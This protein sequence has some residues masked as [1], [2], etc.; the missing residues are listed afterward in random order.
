[1][2]VMSTATLLRVLTGLLERPVACGVCFGSL[3]DGESCLWIA[4]APLGKQGAPHPTFHALLAFK[5]D[6]GDQPVQLGIA[7]VVREIVD[8]AELRNGRTLGAQK[9]VQTRGGI[10]KCSAGVWR[11]P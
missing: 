4:S 3:H 9:V 8:R 1:M 6:L 7:Q 5:S 2:I 11:S 10:E